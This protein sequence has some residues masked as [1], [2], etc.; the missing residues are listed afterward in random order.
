MDESRIL[1][2][3]KSEEY[4]EKRYRQGGKSGKGSIGQARDWKWSV[5]DK[6]VSPV[7]DVVDI[8]CGDLSF[9]EGRTC[10]RYFG[11]DISPHI[12]KRNTEKRPGWAFVSWPAEKH[13]PLKGRVVLCLDVLFHILDDKTATR[14]IE[15]L[16]EYS[17]EWVVVHA[18]WRNPL[19]QKLSDGV[20]Q[21]FR[22]LDK[23]LFS[24]LG[25]DLVEE[26]PDP[27][28]VNPY[29]A[30]YVFKLKTT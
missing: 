1:G 16:C 22:P 8:G 17:K 20:Y 23:T 13:L 29:G 5:I 14:I 12:I 7:E 27:E 24:R 18:W 30:M 3:P 4:W 28:E 10:E 11:I 6:H 19:G 2:R 9:W 15:N 26:T 21:A 25:F